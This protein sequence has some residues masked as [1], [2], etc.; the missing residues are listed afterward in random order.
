VKD[1]RGGKARDLRYNG[2]MVWARILC[3]MML[4][5]GLVGCDAGQVG[6]DPPD[7]DVDAEDACCAED[8]GGASEDDAGVPQD[9]GTVE[10]DEGGALEDDGAAGEDEGAAEDDPG[11]PPARF[12]FAAFADNQF[13]TE[14]CT[15]GVPERLAVPE[16]ILAADV[17]FVL[18]AGDQMDHGYDDGAYAKLV[19]CYAG[20]LAAL[21]YFPALGNHDA[22][23]GAVWDFKAYLEEQ[24][25]TRNPAVWGA[26][27]AEAFPTVYEDDPTSYST[28]PSNPVS[29]TSV[30]SG[31]SFKTFYTFRHQNT[32]FIAFEIGTRW[33]SNTPRTWLEEHLRT[34]R[35][36]P[37]VEHVVVF[38]HHPLYSTTMAES[39][40]GECIEPVRRYYG[41]LF[42]QY[43]V[44]LVLSGHAHVYDRFYVPDDGA[45]TRARPPPASYPWGAQAVHYIVS[46]G[47]GGPLPS[48]CDPAPGERQEL[49][50][51]FSQAR[52]CG[53][54]FLRVE[55]EGRRMR[56]QVI[57]VSGSASDYATAVWDE[58]SIEP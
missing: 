29:G 35:E 14:S 53:F 24:L 5:A 30:P 44:E 15:S 7:A 57:G 58:F 17:D 23:S 32:V 19:E 22:G 50:Y 39:G 34:A 45:A 42:H 6:I 8:D 10:E 46:G 33:W 49:S 54:H 47:G 43:D 36:D 38:M 31:F 26:G 1:R 41:A 9:D 11:P 37:T 51:D 55:V 4:L 18:E 56:I 16:A 2:P 27:Y 20:M 12:S 48:G 52:G 40:D 13:A 28:D 21:P 25:F 3:S